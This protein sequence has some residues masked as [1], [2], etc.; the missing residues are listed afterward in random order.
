MKDKFIVTDNWHSHRP[1]LFE[2]LEKT[3]GIVYEFGVGDGLGTILHLFYIK[4]GLDY[5]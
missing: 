3:T 5:G 2:A 4:T 1:F